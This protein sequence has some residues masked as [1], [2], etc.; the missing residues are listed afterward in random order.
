MSNA[1]AKSLK[2]KTG[3]LLL[4]LVTWGLLTL[5]RALSVE[6]RQRPDWVMPKSKWKSGGNRCRYLL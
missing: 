3:S 6:E 2:I 4:D 1:A 5:T